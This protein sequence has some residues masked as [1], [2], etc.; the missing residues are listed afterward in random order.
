MFSDTKNTQ[1]RDQVDRLVD[2][3]LYISRSLEVF[4]LRGCARFF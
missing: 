3:E 2:E 1:T 4:E